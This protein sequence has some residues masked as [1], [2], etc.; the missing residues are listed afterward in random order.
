MTSEASTGE[1]L[2]PGGLIF[3]SFSPLTPLSSVASPYPPAPWAPAGVLPKAIAGDLMLSSSPA[4]K[5]PA[6]IGPIS[7]CPGFSPRSHWSCLPAHHPWPLEP[8]IP[9]WHCPCQLHSKH[10]RRL[11]TV[12]TPEYP[13]PSAPHE[14]LR[15]GE[16]ALRF[17]PCLH[18]A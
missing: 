15:R 7:V 1:V 9:S 14:R 17:P 13:S 2:D 3:C 5:R 12:S 11:S 10:P 8:V 6:G 18:A 4:Q 16:T